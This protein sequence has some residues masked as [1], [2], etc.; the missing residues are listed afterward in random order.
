[1]AYDD[2]TQPEV[3]EGARLEFV[4]FVV[5]ERPY[6]CWEWNLRE[7]NL[8]FLRGIDPSY[9]TYV[10]EANSEHLEDEEHGRQAALAIRVAYSQALETLF[11]LLGAM[12]QAPECVFGWLLAY[13]NVELE[14]F[15]RKLSQR[16]AVRN[17]L[18]IEPTWESLSAAVH[19]FCNYD[20]DKKDWIAK[21]YARAWARFAGEFLNERA[22]AEYNSIKHGLRAR[23]GGFQLSFGI[24]KVYRQAVPPE[25]MKP[26][27][28]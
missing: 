7:R 20:A 18:N 6:A 12:V 9:Y 19:Q 11:A 14:S 5:D 28:G 25:E 22:S 2:E 3:R 23:L 24:E 16:Q 1:V 8:E 26:L 4:R 27:G 21:G 10:A 15:I 17:R 13:R